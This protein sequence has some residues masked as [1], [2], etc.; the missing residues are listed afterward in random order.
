MAELRHGI[1][2]LAPGAR[3]AKLDAWLTSQLVVRFERRLLSVGAETADIW[4]RITARANRRGLS[5]EA[6]DGLIGA[7]ALEHDFI[8]VTRNVSDFA[9]LEVRLVNPWSGP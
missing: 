8:V 5:V 1:E 6:M 7:Q 3:R 4:G 2:R 9:A